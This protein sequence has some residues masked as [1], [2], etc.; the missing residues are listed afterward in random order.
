MAN[1]LH[2]TVSCPLHVSGIEK[3][4]KQIRIIVNFPVNQQPKLPLPVKALSSNLPYF[5]HVLDDHKAPFLRSTLLMFR[6]L[7][8]GKIASGEA[9][10]DR[11][12][13]RYET[14]SSGTLGN[15]WSSRFVRVLFIVVLTTHDM[16]IDRIEQKLDETSLDGLSDEAGKDLPKNKGL[17]YPTLGFLVCTKIPEDARQPDPN[18]WTLCQSASCARGRGDDLHHSASASWTQDKGIDIENRKTWNL[19]AQ[20]RV[21]GNDGEMVDKLEVRPTADPTE[22]AS[23]FTTIADIVSAL[24]LVGPAAPTVVPIAAGAILAVW[25]RY[26]VALFD[27]EFHTPSLVCSRSPFLLTTMCAISSKFYT[28]RP[29]L[30]QQLAELVQKLAF[31]VPAYL[32]LTPWGSGALERYEYDKTWL[33]LGMAISLPLADTALAA[34]IKLQRIVSR[35]LDF[36]YSG[37]NTPSDLQTDCDYLIII[38]TIETQILA[39]QHEWTS[40]RPLPTLH[41]SRELFWAAK[42]HGAFGG[43]YRPPATSSRGVIPRP[44]LWLLSR[45]TSLCRWLIRSEFQQFIENEQNI[46]DL[47]KDVANVLADVAVNSHHAPALYS[48]FLRTLITA[49]TDSTQES[50]ELSSGDQSDNIALSHG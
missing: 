26:L 14:G 20:P 12:A 4:H 47:V 9:S 45:E 24:V 16:L 37:T 10:I 2:S 8:I 22:P 35:S 31:G 25:T 6:I 46:I 42:R 32:L 28:Q 21:Q 5:G 30:N 41:V 15:N 13:V 27:I 17:I 1:S 29:E 3:L 38:K 19:L 18:N 39:W 33:L 40:T 11:F 7:V 49:R 48:T 34:C 23:L 36:L 50:E 43:G 44:R